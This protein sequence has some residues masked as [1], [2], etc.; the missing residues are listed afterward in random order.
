MVQ[1]WSGPSKGFFSSVGGDYGTMTIH[2]LLVEPATCAAREMG[3]YGLKQPGHH[4][5]QSIW[6]VK[7]QLIDDD[8]GFYYPF[9]NEISHNQLGIP[10]PIISI[11]KCREFPIE[12]W[13]CYD[14][15]L[16]VDSRYL[17]WVLRLYYTQQTW[18]KIRSLNWHINSEDLQKEDVNVE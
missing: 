2:I 15:T 4:P 5:I 7:P 12:F 13:Y 3:S 8:R 17:L 9:Y 14:N 11:I 18:S 16:L 1:Y 10:I 6:A